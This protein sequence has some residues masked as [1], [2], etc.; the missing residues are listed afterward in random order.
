MPPLRTPSGMIVED[1]D[2][3][4]ADMVAFSI[5][6]RIRDSEPG[7]L[8][9]PDPREL[10]SQLRDTQK[11]LEFAKKREDIMRSVITVLEARSGSDPSLDVRSLQIQLERA[12]DKLENLAAT[13]SSRISELELQ[14]SN[15]PS[16]GL[17]NDL[18]E[19]LE[20]TR[21]ELA[22]KK[23]SISDLEER[24]DMSDN[25]IETLRSTQSALEEQFRCSR[26]EI[27]T[28]TEIN[29]SLVK[30]TAEDKKDHKKAEQK[31]NKAMLSIK[32]EYTKN[33]DRITEEHSSEI[34]KLTQDAV[35]LR[36][37]S[38]TA[39]TKLI[40]VEERLRAKETHN[41]ALTEQIHDVHAK[42]AE[43]MKQKSGNYIRQLKEQLATKTATE[44]ET[45]GKISTLNAQLEKS[46]KKNQKHDEQVQ[47]AGDK[48][49]TMKKDLIA[50]KEENRMIQEGLD[51]SDK[52]CQAQKQDNIALQDKIKTLEDQLAEH[53]QVTLTLRAN[54][55]MSK[56]RTE[57][58]VAAAVSDKDAL[59]ADLQKKVDSL[60][61]EVVARNLR[62][63]ELEARNVGYN[64]ADAATRNTNAE[65]ANSFVASAQ[66]KIRALEQLMKNLSVVLPSTGSAEPK[67]T[68]EKS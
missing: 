48:Y 65:L 22:A 29:A 17:N 4:P 23:A 39:H 43:A 15:T 26:L 61:D 59:I 54:E 57:K 42:A 30:S 13:S 24:A 21:L 52:M 64:A 27:E 56:D 9:A 60:S 53:H 58:A 19:Q 37:L 67:P 14:I 63:E 46:M 35:N 40:E 38:D 44:I 45:A 10:R 5:S 36:Q 33:I 49:R 34:S 12:N 1:T 68:G 8:M 18:T 62:I 2:V 41:L 55:A 31:H 16:I 6:Q 20:V 32:R 66:E 3:T 51:T 50:V 11:E 28:L 25:T 47:I 7:E